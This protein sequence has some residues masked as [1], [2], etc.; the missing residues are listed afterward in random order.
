MSNTRIESLRRFLESDPN[1]TELLCDLADAYMDNGQI[2][3]A[4]PYL[5]HALTVNPNHAQCLYKLGIV[6]RCLGK[7]EE[8]LFQFKR[9]QELGHQAPAIQYEL[10]HAQFIGAH[11]QEAAE[12]WKNLLA[13]PEGAQLPNI[14]L[15][16]I[17]ALHYA[18]QLEEA[19]SL[20][21]SLHNQYPQ[22]ATIAGALSTLYL[23]NEEVDKAKALLELAQ[24]QGWNQPELQLT[25]GYLALNDED[26]D[27]A[28]QQFETYLQHKPQEGRA[29]LG[30]A[31]THATSGNVDDAEQ[32]LEK[33]VAAMPTHLGSWHALAWMQLMRN[34]LQAA[35]TTFSKALEMDR[36]F[37]ESWGGMAVIAALKGEKEKAQEY[38]DK[39][40]R[41]DRA[42]M[43]VAAA[44][45]ILRSGN[46]Q[47]PQF[48]SEALQLMAQRPGLGGTNLAET[49]KR[50]AMRSQRKN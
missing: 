17:R 23:D 25:S 45:L 27:L 40:S 42:A 35:E 43:N 31:L 24:Q 39:G 2:A 13:N 12:L 48:L 47:N 26:T 37:G 21:E 18:G 9:L 22:D 38:L 49:I 15:L 34:D 50:L 8:A 14:R 46:M 28:K 1:N 19:I 10:A 16:T 29:L 4:E 44:R 6:Y 20:A 33:T 3:E 41:L 7:P 36:N 32:L 5:E 30:L 11:Y